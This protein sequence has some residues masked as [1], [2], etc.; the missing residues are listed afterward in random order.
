ML[1]SFR[2]THRDSKGGCR[3]RRKAFQLEEELWSQS[4]HW[5]ATESTV[6]NVLKGHVSYWGD[7]KEMLDK[8]GHLHS[9]KAMR[10]LW[11][12]Y[13][14]SCPQRSDDLRSWSSAWLQWER[15]V[16]RGRASWETLRSVG[17]GPWKGYRDP[18]LS[19]SCLLLGESSSFTTES[20][21]ESKSSELRTKHAHLIYRVSLRCLI[22]LMRQMDT[23]TVS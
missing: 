12:A 18:S 23:M 9:P 15:D 10:L 14:L 13:G 22:M 1:T 21:P 5:R 16:L 8:L 4:G 11:S 6:T 2:R 3:E 17:S 20:S 19:S 7:P